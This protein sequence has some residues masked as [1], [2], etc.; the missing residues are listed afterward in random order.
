M[1]LTETKKALL[2]K[3]YDFVNE[4]IG[5]YNQAIKAAQEAANNESKSSAGDKY[6][7]TRALMQIERDNNAKQLAETMKL[8][9]A[10][11]QINP[12]VSHEVSDFGSVLI[13]KQQRYFLS[14]SAGMIK[15]D[16]TPYILLS[17]SS[18]LGRQLL[19]L[20][21]GDFFSY[22]GQKNQVLDIL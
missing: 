17:P 9:Q 13:S 10:L 20:K 18:P 12:N 5:V 16:N 11:D 15:L 3:A 22:N 21:K 7:T 14:I 1:A 8:K 6:E 4:K 19:G 2:E